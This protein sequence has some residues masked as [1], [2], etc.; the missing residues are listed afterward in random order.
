MHM[1]FL[2][3]KV[4]QVPCQDLARYRVELGADGVE[5]VEAGLTA[6]TGQPAYQQI[7]DD[8]RAKIVSG[9][10]AVGEALPSTAKLMEAYGGSITVVRAAIRELQTEG[11]LIGQPGK[12]VYVQ[13][14]PE[15]GAVKP[16]DVA[17]QLAELADTVRRL[18][19]RVKALEKGGSTRK[20]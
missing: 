8:L 11:V 17:S 16:G 12:G 15:A 9:S 14:R 7:A 1:V 13:R 2:V 19:E 6:I 3:H 5:G 10:Y 4:C 20:R 18:D